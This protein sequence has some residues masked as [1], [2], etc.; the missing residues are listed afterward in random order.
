M[1]APAAYGTWASPLRALDLMESAP[2]LGFPCWR[3][4]S[5]IWQERRPAEQGRVAL[6]RRSVLGAETSDILPA[7]MSARTTVHEYGG[8]AWAA[9]ATGTVVTSNLADQRLWVVPPGA[10]PVALTAETASPHHVRFAAPALSP[11]GG[12]AV[13]VRERHMPEGIVNDLVAV[14]VGR[15]PAAP[16]L[17]AGGHDFYSFPEWSP[18]GRELAFVCW[19]HPDMPWDRT[20]L[21]RADFVAGALEHDRVVVPRSAGESVLQPRFGPDGELCYASDRSGWWNLY[22]D[23]RPLAPMEAEFAVPPWVFGDSSYVFLADGTLVATWEA[24]GRGY[25]GVV[26][27]G[28]ALPLDL[29]YTH[30]AD[31]APAG[32]AASDGV[33]AVAA[34]PCVSPGLVR[35]TLEGDVEVLWQNPHPGLDP[36][37]VSVGRR[38]SFPTGQGEEAHAVFYPPHNPEFCGPEGERP[39]LLVTSHG[40]PTSGAR[41][42]LNLSV[43][44]WTTRGFAV[45]DVD[46]RGSTGYGRSFRRALDGRWGDADVEDC[47]N[48]ADWVTAQGWA[49]PARVVVRGSSASGLTALVALARYRTFAGATVLYAVTDLSLFAAVTHKFESRYLDRLVPQ[50][51]MGARSPVNLA[52]RVSAPVLFV[53]GLDD[54]VVPP[55]HGRAMVAS[56]RLAGVGALLI[57]VEGEGHGF[58]LASTRARALEAELAFYGQVLG[59]EPEGDMSRARDDLARAA[60]ALGARWPGEVPR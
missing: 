46:Y 18:D 3:A 24:A 52:D 35:V 17:L 16:C 37:Q 32:A 34:G 19:D 36:T 1:A 53:Q 27:D 40:G 11:D 5:Y 7:G 4:G 10:G 6:V 30:F 20:E 13:C 8:R 44:Y 41:T 56:L 28:R 51:Q 26:T 47:A 43:Q 38:L 60:T 31:L 54:T 33:L 50:D 59:F 29:P 9:D 42:V 15:G 21:H 2:N 23:G 25:L 22:R 14:P 12:W 55:E 48:A 57:E 49:D 45:V 58:H 39:P